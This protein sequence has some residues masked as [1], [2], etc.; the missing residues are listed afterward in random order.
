MLCEVCFVY[1]QAEA[2]VE[3]VTDTSNTTSGDD[4]D[5]DDDDSY[6]EKSAGAADTEGRVE[7][8]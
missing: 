1:C 3:T 4:K 2:N 7:G 5:E 8:R 6:V